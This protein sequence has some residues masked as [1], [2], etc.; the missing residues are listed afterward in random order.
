[1]GYPTR[2]AATTRRT[3]GS[4][5]I[6]TAAPTVNVIELC[7]GT[8]WASA[9]RIQQEGFRPSKCGL[10]GPGVYLAH[11]EKATGF[12]YSR[13]RHKGE[14]AIVTVQATFSRKFHS[15]KG[16]CENWQHE[17]YDA[18]YTD[19][20]SRSQKPEWCFKDA[21]QIRVIKIQR[22]PPDV[23]VPEEVCCGEKREEHKF[24]NRDFGFNNK[25]IKD[26]VLYLDGGRFR[27]GE[28]RWH[29][30]TFAVEWGPGQTWVCRIKDPNL[31]MHSML[32]L[33]HFDVSMTEAYLNGLNPMY[34]EKWN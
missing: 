31:G 4:P 32:I 15:T 16:D 3:T 11:E 33:R 23:D 6:V 20:T 10:L 24:E 22:L 25:I 27:V 9:Q 28:G 18:C 2:K 8:S 29:G 17:G 14:P 26:S 1:M 30:R 34:V 13:R 7:H 19:F 21:K 12:G 5:S